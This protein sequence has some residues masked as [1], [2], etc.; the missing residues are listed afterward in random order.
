MCHAAACKEAKLCDSGAAETLKS[1][2]GDG[3]KAIYCR[4]CEQEMAKSVP[5]RG[6]FFEKR[7]CYTLIRA[8]GEAI[9]RGSRRTRQTRS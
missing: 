9:L 7:L 5:I 6:L 4:Y 1:A 8:R 2:R 3:L